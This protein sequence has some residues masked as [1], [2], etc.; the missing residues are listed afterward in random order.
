MAAL[1]RRGGEPARR[2]PGAGSL[3]T[4]TPVFG[5]SESGAKEKRMD[6]MQVKC[7]IL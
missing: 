4:R 2:D 7:F 3:V 1:K 6:G 5:A